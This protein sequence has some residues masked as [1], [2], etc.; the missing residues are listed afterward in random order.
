MY[1]S[2]AFWILSSLPFCILLEQQTSNFASELLNPESFL[3]LTSC[4]PISDW[5]DEHYRSHPTPAQESAIEAR[6][7]RYFAE[8]A[9]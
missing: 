4:D 6:R 8:D 9:R 3:E 1:Q 7:V 2:F 5:S